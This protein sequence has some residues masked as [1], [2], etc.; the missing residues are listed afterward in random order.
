VLCAPDGTN[1]AVLMWLSRPSVL[2]GTLILK[3]FDSRVDFGCVL[4]DRG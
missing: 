4:V 1:G 3:F 2:I